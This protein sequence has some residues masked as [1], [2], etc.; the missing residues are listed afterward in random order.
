MPST[1]KPEVK[2]E[3]TESDAESKSEMT[4]QEEIAPPVIPG[5]KSNQND[6]N[7]FMAEGNRLYRDIIIDLH[8]DVVPFL[9][10]NATPLFPDGFCAIE[11]LLKAK[12]VASLKATFKPLIY[13]KS[14]SLIKFS[15]FFRKS[16]PLH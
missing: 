12:K 9:E 10:K 16:L 6:L 8:D 5:P 7:T 14:F 13:L 4:P 11:G 2:I 3:I 1:P 15:S